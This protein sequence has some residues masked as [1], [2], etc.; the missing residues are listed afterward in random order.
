MFFK[1]F[2]HYQFSVRTSV[3]LLIRI[4]VRRLFAARANTILTVDFK[5]FSIELIGML[6]NNINS[7]GL[8]ASGTLD[9]VGGQALD[10][11]GTVSWTVD[12]GGSP[13]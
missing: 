9:V 10:G 4:N 11:S 6:L 5:S 12:G 1:H 2:W 3:L 13:C 8:S 7:E